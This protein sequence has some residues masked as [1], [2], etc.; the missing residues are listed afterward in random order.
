MT[1]VYQSLDQMGITYSRH[2]HVAVFTT[3]ESEGHLKGKL[4]ENTK[5]LF[6]ADEKDQRFFLLTIQHHKRADLKKFAQEIGERRL[7]FANDG[8]L[9]K[10]LGITPGSVSPLG[11]LNDKD[12]FVKFYMDEDLLKQEKIYVHPNINTATL[13]IPIEDFKKIMAFSGHD[14]RQI[15]VSLFK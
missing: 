3:K 2:D 4:E 12:G 15:K 11:L 5:N 7:H 14:I 6:L 1:D 13:E 8:Y 9:F 10:L